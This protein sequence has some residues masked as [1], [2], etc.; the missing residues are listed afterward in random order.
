MYQC[1]INK[2]A[3]G[4]RYILKKTDTDTYY[5]AETTITFDLVGE[6]VAYS[7]AEYKFTESTS[8]HYCLSENDQNVKIVS[9]LDYPLSIDTTINLSQ[10]FEK[11][12]ENGIKDTNS[13]TLK[14]TTTTGEAEEQEEKILFTVSLSNLSW[15]MSGVYLNL[16]IKYLSDSGLLLYH[17]G[18]DTTKLLSLQESVSTG[19]RIVN[20]MKVNKML[21]PGRFNSAGLTPVN[22]EIVFSITTENKSDYQL[23][24]VG[25][26]NITGHGLTNVI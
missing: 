17:F 25:S 15:T 11:A 18:D 7:V 16:H 20:Y 6:P 14:C 1:K 23:S 21:W 12:T 22:Y 10:L 3:E 13:F 4:S 19:E 2:I 5:Y 9:D 8:N 26:V 24:K